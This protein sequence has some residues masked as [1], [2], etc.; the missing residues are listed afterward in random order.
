MM[1]E[2]PK[3]GKSGDILCKICHKPL[4]EHSFEEQQ[5]CAK[6]LLE[7]DGYTIL[8]IYPKL[9]FLILILVHK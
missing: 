1:T 7:Q 6:K 4:K 5:E 3:P 8:I 9:G 2:P